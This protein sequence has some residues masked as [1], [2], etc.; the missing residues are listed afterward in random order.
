MS[1]VNVQ[2]I[3]VSDPLPVDQDRVKKEYFTSTVVPSVC[4]EQQYKQ[5]LL[6]VEQEKLNSLNSNAHKEASSI[7]ETA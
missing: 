7:L 3:A 5:F 1:N 2:N 6:M 4:T